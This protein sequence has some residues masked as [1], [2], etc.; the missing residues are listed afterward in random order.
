MV[1]L[2]PIALQ[3]EEKEYQ[4]GK[5]SALVLLFPWLTELT[6]VGPRTHTISQHPPEDNWRDPPSSWPQ[7]P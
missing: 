1:A 3:I 7:A 2:K 5:R 4:D 6:E